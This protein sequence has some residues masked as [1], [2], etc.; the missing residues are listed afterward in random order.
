MFDTLKFEK[1]KVQSHLCFTHLLWLR[2]LMGEEWIVPCEV[3]TLR[4]VQLLR[5]QCKEW[6]TQFP[7]ELQ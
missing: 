1:L 5:L 7:M 4:L 3:G 2:E 6:V